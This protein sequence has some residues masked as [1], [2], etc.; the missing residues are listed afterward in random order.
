MFSARAWWPNTLICAGEAHARVKV[1][2]VDI[3]GAASP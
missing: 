3:P 1:A 2:T